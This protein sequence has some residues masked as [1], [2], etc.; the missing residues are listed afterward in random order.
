M[1]EE[2]SDRIGVEN[3]WPWGPSVGD[4]NADGFQDVFIA[5]GM[6]YPFRY[7]VNSVLIN[8]RGRRFRDAEFILGI[9]PRRDESTSAPWY[10]I[11]CDEP[12]YPVDPYASPV[13]QGINHLKFNLRKE[14]VRILPRL[15]SRFGPPLHLACPGHDGEIQV[16][17][18]RST[19]SAAIFD[20]DDD[21]DLDIV[22]NEFNSEPMVLMSNLAKQK[23]QSLRFLKVRLEGSAGPA[24]QTEPGSNREGIG[25]RVIVKAGRSSYTQVMD[26]KSGYL[27]QSILPLYFGLGDA[28]KIDSIEVHWPSGRIQIVD[29]PIKMNSLLVIREPAADRR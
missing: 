8:D 2:I 29:A 19:R 28:P 15:R 22:T 25:A 1:Y 13:R 24:P 21:G 9:E 27:S 20:L 26:G 6:G 3:F 12:E 17:G 10:E 23:G 18:A 7:G 11:N 14:V 5:S 16:M 4:L